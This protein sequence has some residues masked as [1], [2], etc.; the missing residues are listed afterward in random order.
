[1]TVRKSDDL[2]RLWRRLLVEEE[3]AAEMGTCARSVAEAHA[4]AV[5]RTWEI[6]APY[7]GS[8]AELPGGRSAENARD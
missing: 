1:M 5:E 6:V 8:G 4:N 7:V 3:I 2:G